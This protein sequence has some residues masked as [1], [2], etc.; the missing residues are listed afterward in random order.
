MAD[1]LFAQPADLAAGALV[2]GEVGD[3]GFGEEK[4]HGA[5]LYLRS[6]SLRKSIEPVVNIKFGTSLQYGNSP[7]I[8]HFE[9]DRR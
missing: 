5:G 7:A 3:V 9:T 1:A 4:A 2:S 6:G 8:R